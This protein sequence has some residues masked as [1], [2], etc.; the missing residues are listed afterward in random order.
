MDRKTE[1]AHARSELKKRVKADSNE[2]SSCLSSGSS[3][4]DSDSDDVIFVVGADEAGRGP[5]IGPVTCSAVCMP[6]S[7]KGAQLKLPASL[8]ELNDSKKLSEK[9]RDRLAAEIKNQIK[10][11]SSKVVTKWST[12]S[13]AASATVHVSA[14]EIDSLNIL[15]ASLHGMERAA[16]ECVASMKK[17]KK[18]RPTPSA[19]NTIFLFDGPHVPRSLRKEANP[20][21]APA[22]LNEKQQKE[23]AARAAILKK[24]ESL[25]SDNDSG[26]MAVGVVKGDATCPSIAAAS[27]LAKTAR[28]AVMSELVVHKDFELAS[29]K[30]YP[31]TAHLAALTK[32]GATPQHRTTFAPVAK[33]LAAKKAPAPKAAKKKAPA[34]KVAKK[35]APAAPAAKKAAAPAPKGKP[36]VAKTKAPAAKAAKR[37]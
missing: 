8:A 5:L 15:E 20:K 35:K 21:K 2:S 13:C 22:K 29:N 7:A 11:Q 34:P 37:K 3:S 31:T 10:T 23:Q 28:D 24:I 32:H 18:L 4:D 26:F 16:D 9:A 1:L 33:A 19:K 36:K 30:G 12:N 14:K 27:V 25:K 6:L 17:L